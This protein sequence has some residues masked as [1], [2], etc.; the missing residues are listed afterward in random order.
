M[1][2][3]LHFWLFWLP[4][5]QL[6]GCFELYSGKLPDNFKFERASDNHRSSIISQLRRFEECDGNEECIARLKEMQESVFI[7]V[8]KDGDVRI[9]N[10]SDTEVIVKFDGDK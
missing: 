10:N 7:T 8:S 6:F 5:F 1:R 3:K 2:N 9:E 4:F